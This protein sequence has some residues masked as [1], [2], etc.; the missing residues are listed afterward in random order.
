MQM[1]EVMNYVKACNAVWIRKFLN[2]AD[3]LE[4]N[5]NCKMFLL[6]PFDYLKKNSYKH[7]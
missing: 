7:S 4:G 6:S 2:T 1:I 3:T 5:K